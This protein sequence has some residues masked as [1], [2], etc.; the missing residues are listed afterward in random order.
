MNLPEY[1]SKVWPQEKRGV[2][3]A[4]IKEV[5]PHDAAYRRW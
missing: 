3:L 5:S 1:I 4:D 2:G